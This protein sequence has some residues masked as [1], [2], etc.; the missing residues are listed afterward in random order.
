[1]DL[2]APGTLYGDRL[3]QVD[4]RV[5]KIFRFGAKGRVQGNL[6]LYNML[7]ANPVLA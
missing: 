2:V 5:S 1:M 3:N 6:D 7:N 4:F